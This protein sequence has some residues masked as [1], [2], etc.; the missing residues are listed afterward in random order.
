MTTVHQLTF[1]RDS[2]TEQHI[3]DAQNA[4][5]WPDGELHEVTLDPG[6]MTVEGT[7]EGVRWLYDYLRYLVDAWRQEGE[8]WDADVAEE[9]A[10]QVWESV[11]DL[12]DQQRN[13]RIH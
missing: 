9:M 3:R 1:E 12:P 13:R 2:I 6:E 5:D 7:P 10:E 4:D 11:D 8:Q